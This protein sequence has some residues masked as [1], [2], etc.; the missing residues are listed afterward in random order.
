MELSGSIVAEQSTP[1]RQ[2]GQRSVPSDTFIALRDLFQDVQQVESLFDADPRIRGFEIPVGENATRFM[3]VVATQ[4]KL[5][6]DG[7]P[8]TPLVA[9]QTIEDDTL[10][11]EKILDQVTTATTAYRKNNPDFADKVI[12]QLNQAKNS[13]SPVQPQ[14]DEPR[15]TAVLPKEVVVEA[16]VLI[17]LRRATEPGITR[18]IH[19]GFITST[20]LGEIDLRDGDF[21]FATEVSATSLSQ[22][23][24][25][26]NGNFLVP[27]FGVTAE[28]N[29]VE[30]SRFPQIGGVISRHR[31]ALMSSGV[32]PTGQNVGIFSRPSSGKFASEIFY[33]PVS[34]DSSSKG[35]ASVLTQSRFRQGDS[36]LFAQVS[37]S[38]LVMKEIKAR[39]SDALASPK[40]ANV[41]KPRRRIE[42]VAK[43]TKRNAEYYL[44]PVVSGIKSR[45]R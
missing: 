29:A 45:L 30:S 33:L 26:S 23:V 39:V 34:E 5:L 18:Y 7:N 40:H 1:E 20:A 10:D 28:N 19:P 22:R 38:P 41:R 44:G 3:R 14:I 12:Q 27:A 42:Q 35:L 37:R 36:F 13:L 31:T 15:G 8:N 2:A 6:I 11:L 17:G 24:G 43:R 4:I 9:P 25:N 32:T 21:I 16:P